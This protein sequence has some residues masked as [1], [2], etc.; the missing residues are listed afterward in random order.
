MLMVNSITFIFHRLSSLLMLAVFMCSACGGSWAVVSTVR[1]TK[2]TPVV[3]VQSP[4]K[5]HLPSGPI[6]YVALGASDA[7]GIGS[8]Q[9]GSQGYVPLIAAHLPKGSHM[10][11]L[12]ISGERL[13][14][15]LTEELP[16]ALST[17]PELVTVWLVANDFVGGVPYD[18][19]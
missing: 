3:T 11:N 8:N 16:I 19:Y 6:V 10:I 12:G 13:H 1:S 17:S 7:V 4:I 18:A 5:V 9:P 2:V 14:N 15:A